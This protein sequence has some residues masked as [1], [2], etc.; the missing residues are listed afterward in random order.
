MPII[1][2]KEVID[3]IMALGSYPGS[4]S[5]FEQLVEFTYPEPTGDVKRYGIIYV[6]E[7]KTKYSDKPNYKVL[8]T[9]EGAI[10]DDIVKMTEEIGGYDHEMLEVEL[11][12]GDKLWL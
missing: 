6:G 2:D 8:W 1:D 12:A 4:L 10:L 9:R 11:K 7:D 5:K 3:T